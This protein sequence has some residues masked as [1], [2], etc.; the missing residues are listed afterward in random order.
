MSQIWFW[1]LGALEPGSFTNW[2]LICSELGKSHFG[3][4]CA[5]G[6]HAITYGHL[7]GEVLRRIDGRTIGNYFREEIAEPLDLDFW[8]GL[9][10]KEFIELQ[11]SIH[12]NQVL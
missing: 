3:I 9:P 2:E 5:H 12:L 11:T 10:E 1:E 7:V 8:I 6:Y 4:R